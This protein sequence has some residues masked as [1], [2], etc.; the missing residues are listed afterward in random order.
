MTKLFVVR[1]GESKHNLGGERA[2]TFAGSQIDTELAQKGIEAAEILSENLKNKNISLIF[3]S[4]LKRSRETA[5]IIRQKLCLT[6]EIIEIPELNEFNV[7]DFAGHTEEEV[8]VLFPESAKYFYDGEIENWAFPNGENYKN[9]SQRIDLAISK[10]KKLSEDRTVLI[11]AHGMINRTIFYKL[12]K[13]N[14][15]NWQLRKYPHDKIV[16]LELV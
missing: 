13:Q 8:R 15:D 5:E 6:S 12:D 2:H 7:G 16:E 1:H 3:C 4:G 14:I 9:V 10:I 11:V